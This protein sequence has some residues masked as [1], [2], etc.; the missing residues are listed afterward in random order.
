MNGDF[1]T[2]EKMA[3][4]SIKK[5]IKKTKQKRLFS[6]NDDIRFYKGQKIKIH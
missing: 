1:N 2:S 6:G 5:I 3:H 4:N